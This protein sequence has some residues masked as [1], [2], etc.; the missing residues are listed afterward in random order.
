MN[1]D[2]RPFGLPRVATSRD[3]Q[4][5]VQLLEPW[6]NDGYV[7]L[8]KPDGD[9]VIVQVRF[10]PDFFLR[11]TMLEGLALDQSYGELNSRPERLARPSTIPT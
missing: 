7:G 6:A 4:R 9:K 2:Y 11:R 10:G 8:L 1:V 5:A 3:G